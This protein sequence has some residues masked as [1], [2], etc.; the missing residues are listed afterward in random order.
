M[1]TFKAIANGYGLG[2]LPKAVA[3]DLCCA[4]C[5]DTT[6]PLYSSERTTLP[7]SAWK[8]GEAYRRACDAR[9]ERMRNYTFCRRCCVRYYAE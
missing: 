9:R 3:A 5:S 1:K 4:M 8:G 2:R 7:A 6:A